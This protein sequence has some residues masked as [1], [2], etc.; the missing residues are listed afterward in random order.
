MI[1]ERSWKLIVGFSDAFMS[2][3]TF[4]SEERFTAAE[5]ADVESPT[6]S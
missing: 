5:V 1:A 4:E 6:E 3:G 2:A